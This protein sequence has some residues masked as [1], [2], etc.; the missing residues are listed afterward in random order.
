MSFN[1]STAAS[2]SSDIC[3]LELVYHYCFKELEV[4][5]DTLMSSG[6]LEPFPNFKNIYLNSFPGKQ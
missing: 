4:T 2:N 6:V 3:L 5:Q 1:L